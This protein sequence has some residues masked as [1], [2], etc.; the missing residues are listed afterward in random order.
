M[1]NGKYGMCKQSFRLVRTPALCLLPPSLLGPFSIY[2]VNSE[3]A[4]GDACTHERYQWAHSRL[5]KRS[6]AEA[7]RGKEKKMDKERKQKKKREKKKSLE[8]TT[9]GQSEL[10]LAYRLVA[11]MDFFFLLLFSF[12]LSAQNSDFLRSRTVEILPIAHLIIRSFI[13]VEPYSSPILSMAQ[14]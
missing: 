1:R 13:F 4:R 7:A 14:L 10:L 9:G 3:A 11:W 8:P 5:M 12:F 6:G 2:K